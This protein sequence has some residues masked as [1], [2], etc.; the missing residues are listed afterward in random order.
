VDSNRTVVFSRSGADSREIEVALASGQADFV[1]LTASIDACE[2]APPV[3]PTTLSSPTTISGV[4]DVEGNGGGLPWWLIPLLI[5]LVLGLLWFLRR[6]SQQSKFPVGAELRQRNV[7]QNPGAA[8]NTRADLSGLREMRFSVDRNGW[9][10]EA[11]EDQAD[12]IVR[13]IRSRTEGDFLVVQP[14]RGGD[15]AEVREG[16]RASHA[17]STPGESGVGIPVRNTYIRV[18]VPEEYEENEEIE[19]E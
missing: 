16:T 3:T 7:T 5:G 6:R 18:E 8:W 10:V 19:E 13:R 2:V 12:I 11:D 4:V 9:L 1:W 15:D 14:A 17:F